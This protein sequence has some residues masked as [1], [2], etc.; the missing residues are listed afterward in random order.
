MNNGVN[1]AAPL[2]P[3]KIAVAAM[4]THAGNMNR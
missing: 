4:T 3:L 1:G 2:I